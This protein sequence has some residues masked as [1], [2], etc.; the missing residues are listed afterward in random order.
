LANETAT[1]AW[2]DDCREGDAFKLSPE[3]YTASLTATA[4]ALH[5]L[6]YFQSALSIPG[7]PA[8]ISWILERQVLE[9]ESS[10]FVGG[11]EEGNGTADPNLASTYYALKALDLTNAY[12]SVN[13]SAV[14]AFILN[15]Q[16]VDGSWGHVPDE[17]VGFLAYAGQACEL[18]NIIGDAVEI[19]ASSQDPNAPSGFILDWRFLVVGGIIVLA[20]ALAVASL[21]WD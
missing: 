17:D 21:R 9:S 16:A 20:L 13:G 10:D 14:T 12:S 19:L 18:L 2:I 6:S 1:L 3:S 4:A 11:F 7:L 8:T 15:C 5:A